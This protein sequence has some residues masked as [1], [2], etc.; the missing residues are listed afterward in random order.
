MPN[1]MLTYRCNLNCPYCFANEFVNKK[2]T[3]KLQNE[4]SQHN[5]CG[6]KMGIAKQAGQREIFANR[7]NRADVIG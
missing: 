2:N 4:K 1:I 3:D 5:F 6:M 7:L